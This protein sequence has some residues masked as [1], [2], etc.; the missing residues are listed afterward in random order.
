[1]AIIKKRYGYICSN[2]GEWLLLK[3]DMDI[4]AQIMV[5]VYY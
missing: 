2:Y 5:N 4:Y 1:M 3:K